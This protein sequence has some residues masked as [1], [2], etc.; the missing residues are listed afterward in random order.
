M[1]RICCAYVSIL[2]YE[3]KTGVQTNQIGVVMKLFVVVHIDSGLQE[4]HKRFSSFNEA[5]SYLGYKDAWVIGFDFNDFKIMT[6]AQ[7]NKQ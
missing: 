4:T 7:F 3:R 6:L 2:A 1:L 5:E